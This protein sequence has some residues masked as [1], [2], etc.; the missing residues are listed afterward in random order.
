M[1]KSKKNFKSIF[2]TFALAFT[3]LALMLGIFLGNALPHVK[4]EESA[5]EKYYTAE[6]LEEMKIG[7]ILECDTGLDGKHLLFDVTDFEEFIM[8]PTLIEL[9]GIVEGA[10]G[11][12][13]GQ[14]IF[15]FENNIVEGPEDTIW[16]YFV[17]GDGKEYVY[18]YSNSIPDTYET[19]ILYEGN[20]WYISEAIE[21]PKVEPEKPNNN[22]SRPSTDKNVEEDEKTEGGCGSFIEDVGVVVNEVLKI[23][24]VEPFASGMV[25]VVL[26]VLML[27][28][29]VLAIK[30]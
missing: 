14:M 8:S 10:N 21:E 4:A 2:K 25:T 29:A 9:A 30:K 18:L 22:N 20:A 12:A 23:D 6:K 17:A 3:T 5:F 16:K 19:M 11:E 13:L 15:Y 7:E 27:G 28:I 26:G 24:D 1:T